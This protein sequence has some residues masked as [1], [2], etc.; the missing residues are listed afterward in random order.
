MKT[1]AAILLVLPGVF[2]A[3]VFVYGPLEDM[4]QV[5]AESFFGFLSIVSA[6][7]CLCWAW[8]VRHQSR[9]LAWACGVVGGLYL[10]LFIVVPLVFALFFPPKTKTATRS[11]RVAP[12]DAG[13]PL[14]LRSGGRWPGTP[15]PRCSTT[16]HL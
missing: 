12:G 6:L 2:F 8:F 1:I 10:V 11:E 14:C 4:G 5:T 15:E 7:A 16:R 9:K 13:M 3:M